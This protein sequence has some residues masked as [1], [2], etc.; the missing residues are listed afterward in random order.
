MNIPKISV[1]ELALLLL[2]ILKPNYTYAIQTA[3]C[4][5]PNDIN[6]IALTYITYHAATQNKLGT[7][8]TD[9]ERLDTSFL[10]HQETNKTSMYAPVQITFN[11]YY[12]CFFAVYSV[13]HT[14][15][16]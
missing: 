10:N 6:D 16:L 3:C 9:Y 7:T 14:D 5:S 12:C 4:C 8:A 1:A 13:P 2:V 11:T 15:P